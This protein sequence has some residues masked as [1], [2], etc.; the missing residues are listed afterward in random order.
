MVKIF[1]IRI[2]DDLY[3]AIEKWRST[4]AIIPTR[5]SAIRSILWKGLE[6]FQHDIDERNRGD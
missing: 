2:A 4:H 5:L 1:T 3:L 6:A